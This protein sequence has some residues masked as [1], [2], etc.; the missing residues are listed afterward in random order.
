MMLI[1]SSW[2]VFRGLFLD[3]F[4]VCR[5]EGETKCSVYYLW[6]FF[7]SGGGSR[8][9]IKTAPKFVFVLYIVRDSL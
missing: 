8:V 3:A 2:F 9:C 4:S 1:L 6:V 5:L 7:S